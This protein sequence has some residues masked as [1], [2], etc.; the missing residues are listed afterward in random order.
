MLGGALHGVL[1]DDF[2]IYY[3]HSL[4]FLLMF[5]CLFILLFKNISDICLNDSNSCHAEK[6][7]MPRPFSIP[8][9][10]DFLVRSA[11]LGMDSHTQ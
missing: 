11:V 2:M 1:P 10:S 3:S 7:K 4:P 6:T 5:P 8:R 9:R